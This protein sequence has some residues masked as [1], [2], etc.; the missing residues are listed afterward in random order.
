[1]TNS[2]QPDVH[3]KSEHEKVQEMI[4]SADG[5]VLGVLTGQVDMGIFMIPDKLVFPVSRLD[6]PASE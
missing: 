3:E 2:E 4:Q 6:K 1:M 5:P